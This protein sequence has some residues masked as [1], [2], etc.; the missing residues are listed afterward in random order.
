MATA[1]RNYIDNNITFKSG[2]TTTKV[3]QRIHT[4]KKSLINFATDKEAKN[5]IFSIEKDDKGQIYLHFNKPE[6]LLDSEG[7]KLNIDQDIVLDPATYSLNIMPVKTGAVGQEI[8]VTVK[9]KAR[10]LLLKPTLPLS[11]LIKK[12]KNMPTKLIQK[13]IKH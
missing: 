3:T 4:L 1:K 12:A 10:F 11:C 5:A 6:L 8:E 7:N 13:Q 9:D 2:N